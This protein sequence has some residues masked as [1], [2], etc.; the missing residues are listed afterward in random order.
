MALSYRETTDGSE[1]IPGNLLAGMLRCLHAQNLDFEHIYPNVSNWLVE[2]QDGRVIREVGINKQGEPIVVGPLG[3][4]GGLWTNLTIRFSERDGLPIDQKVFDENWMQAYE[5][6]T[7][8]VKPKPEEP[9]REVKTSADL[10]GLWSAQGADLRLAFLPDGRGFFGA[11]NYGLMFYD[12]FRWELREES[13]LCIRGTLS[14]T[15]DDSGEVDSQPSLFVHEDIPIKIQTRF[16]GDGTPSK[17]L[18]APLRNDRWNW[19]ADK[20]IR[21]MVPLQEIKEPSFRNN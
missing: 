16:A 13:R 11:Y 18:L 17:V 9:I 7:P 14:F 4:N 21:S 2:I 15:Q 8:L 19:I 10:W 12:L 20:Y 1:E 3:R 5:K 6:L